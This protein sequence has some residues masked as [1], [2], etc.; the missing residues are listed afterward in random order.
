MDA[1][2]LMRAGRLSEAR[3]QLTKEVKA[4]PSDERK[5]TLLFQVLAFDGEWEKA[6]RHLDIMGSLS[7]QLEV[8]V[9]VYKNLVIAERERREVAERK[10]F[11]GFVS[12]T[13]PYLEAYL[14][15]WDKV[16]EKKY[17]EAETLYDHV[18]SQRRPVSGTINGKRFEG[19]SDTDSFL[20]CFLEAIVHDRYIWI[21]FESLGELSV[22]EPK[23]LFDLLWIPA[24][25]MTWE[26][27]AVACYLPVTYPWSFRHEDER[28]KLGRITDWTNL[29]RGFYRGAGQH[30]YQIGEGD[31]PLLE[32]RDIVF[33]I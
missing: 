19:L 18:V 24:R 14:A 12:G 15:A 17:D 29:G 9:L 6:E 13:P 16:G 5:R 20:A 23:T 22:A 7:S 32:I 21:P 27:L 28:I 26:G 31:V 3:E 1:R 4:S 25:I 30:I 11:P 10:R 33:R 8:G 2:E